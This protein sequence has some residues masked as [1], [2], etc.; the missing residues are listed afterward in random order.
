MSPPPCKTP[1]STIL[2]IGAVNGIVSG[3]ELEGRF[4]R[5]DLGMQN[6]SS[7]VRLYALEWH[8]YQVRRYHSLPAVHQIEID[9]SNQCKCVCPIPFGEHR[10]L[11]HDN[12]CTALLAELI[13]LLREFV[14][15]DGGGAIDGRRSAQTLCRSKIT[16]HTAP[17]DNGPPHRALILRRETTVFGKRDFCPQK[18]SPRTSLL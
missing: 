8:R 10:S 17:P 15:V 12:R 14:Y 7:T 16:L 11:A 5:A 2:A 9:G 13:P 6:L 4:T 3:F 1:Q 18:E